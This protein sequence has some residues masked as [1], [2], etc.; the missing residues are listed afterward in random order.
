LLNSVLS[1]SFWFD[2]VCFLSFVSSLSFPFLYYLF[3]VRVSVLFGEIKYT[4]VGIGYFYYFLFLAGGELFWAFF[5]YLSSPHHH[6][7]HLHKR[8]TTLSLLPPFLVGLCLI[9]VALHFFSMFLFHSHSLPFFHSIPFQLYP[10]LTKSK[11]NEETKKT[12]KQ[13]NMAK[14]R[15]KRRK[16]KTKTVDSFI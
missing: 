3:G 14:K 2:V 15:K 1:D 5:L 6:S 7:H 10:I 4:A 9:I 12:T 16:T 8:L 11:R 13:Q